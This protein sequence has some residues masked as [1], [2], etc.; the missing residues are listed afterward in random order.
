MK[1][2]IYTIAKNEEAH[3]EKWFNSVV[4]ADYHLICDT[5]SSD[6][7]VKI[8]ENLGIRTERISVQPWRFD[9][10]R[11]A[12][13]A[14]LPDDVDYCISLDMDEVLVTG[15]REL[16][17]DAFD[18]GIQWPKYDYVFSWA[19]EGVPSTIF[20]GIKIHPRWGVRWKYPIHEV[21]VAS[22]NVFH[23]WGKTS[24]QMHH[25]QD[26]TKP[27]SS[28]LPMLELAVQE[29]QNSA[30]LSYY[31]AREYYYLK[32]YG[33]STIEFSRYLNFSD[34]Y[35]QAERSEAL[36]Y[37]GIMNPDKAEHFFNLSSE[38]DPSS[39]EPLLDLSQYYSDQSMWSKSLEAAQAALKIKNQQ[40][41]LIANH[42][43]WSWR[44][45]DLIALASYYLGDF[46]TALEHGQIALS[47]LPEDP[48]LLKNLDFYLEKTS[49]KANPP[50]KNYGKGR[51][52]SA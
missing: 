13:L 17:Q 25:F 47:Y 21:P 48:R 36:R 38:T 8:A 2:A 15:W 30:R 40:I 5:G 52:L 6:N 11:N 24:I 27:R 42:A 45:H 43:S 46:S 20:E 18:A 51:K 28:Y 29:D 32:R 50:I 9:D 49:Q 35:F 39:R 41:G 7:T 34:N 44:P 26:A 14:L 3:V 12:A 31:L 37:L 16:L 1:V 19:S 33:E 10:S 4:E 22:P 23:K